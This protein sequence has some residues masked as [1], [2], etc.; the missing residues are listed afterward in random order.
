MKTPI[1]VFLGSGVG[2]KSLSKSSHT[3]EKQK[4]VIQ[5]RDIE[6]MTYDEI[7]KALSIPVNNV[8]VTLHRARQKVKAQLLNVESYGL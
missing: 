6:Q 1:F 5:L 3:P 8:K 7:S 2:C 4:M